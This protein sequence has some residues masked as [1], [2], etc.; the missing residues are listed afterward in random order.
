MTVNTSSLLNF[1][2]P[3]L[4]EG[5][6]EKIQ[7][8]SKDGKVEISTLLKDKNI[9]TLLNSLFKDILQGSKS[10][11]SISQALQNSKA[12][13]DFKTVSSDLKDIINTAS[14]NP[15]LQQQV[16]TLKTFL[17]DIKDIDDKNLKSNI[18]NSGV[19]L[20]SKLLKNEPNITSDLKASL[21][22]VKEHIDDPKI[23]KVLD[24]ISYHQL[25]SFS[26]YSNNT[27][28]PFMWDNIDDASVNINSNENEV[29]TCSID[30]KLKDYGELKSV[31]LLENKNNI[32]IN[33]RIKSDV[34][35]EKVQDNLQVL[36]EKINK[37]GLNLISL[38]VLTYNDQQTKEQKA[39]ESIN[40]LSYG[41]DIKA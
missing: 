13:F 25:M 7:S 10:K 22:Q 8:M 12:M 3:S 35:K 9:Q 32:S 2:K 34:L 1:L 29:F 38:N 6:K 40:K 23:Q 36:R 41:I 4:N 18:K 30:L 14:K 21:L 26:S 17:V 27:F 24:Q 31:L 16:S 19:F 28:L 15:K 39:Y 33:L 11:A 20:E 5:I 37:I